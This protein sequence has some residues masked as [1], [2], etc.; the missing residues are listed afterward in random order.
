MSDNLKKYSFNDLLKLG[1]IRIPKIQRDYAQGRQNQ[2]VDEIRKV[3]VHTLLLVVKGKRPATELDF[4]YGSINNNAFEPL[5]GQQRLTTLFLLHW[6]MGVSL[7]MPEDKKHSIFTYETRNT[8]NEFCDELVQHEA[9]NIVQETIKN[10][11]LN[12]LVKD[13]KEKKPELPS[14]IIK[15]RDWFKWEWK[16]DPTILSML[17]MIDAIF[18]EMG[19]DWN[20]DL[21]VYRN[22]LEHITFNLLNLG[23]FGLSN[24]LFIKMNARGKQLSDFD[25]L[26]STLEEE[27]QIQ[28]KEM[29]EQGNKLASEE[30]EEMWRSLMDG[31]W[32][33]LFW[34]KYARQMIDNTETI[35]PEERKKDR[36]QAAKLSELQFKKLLLR[37]IALQLFENNPSSEKLAEAS[38]NLE[39]STIDNLLFV[40]TDSLTDLRSDETHT[41]V[42]STSLTIN[43]KRLIEDINLLIYKDS[44][45]I[46]YD[47]SYLLPE[48]S[49]IDKDKSSLFDTFLE[50]KVPNDVELIFYA[51]LLF[52]RSFP[53]KKYK[54]SEEEPIAWYFDK[55]AHN[56]WLKNYEDWVRSTRNILLN[57]N[58]N[59]RIDKI[60][61]SKEATQSLKQMSADLTAFVEE[62]GLDIE[63]DSTIIKQFFKSSN[64]N[65]QRLD[66]QSL[67]EERRKALLVLDDNKE[68]ESF[69]DDAE[70]HPY[71]WGQIRCLLNW[72]NGNLDSFKEYSKRLRQLLDCIK[73]NGLLY[74][75][76]ILSFAPNCW[77]ENNRLFLYN[78]D[79]DNSFKR[80]LREHTKE[81]QAYGVA[82]KSLIDIW[83]QSYSSLS[84]SEFLD[85]LI[86]TKKDN[87]APWI[88]CIIKCPSVL[89]ETWNKR[90]YFQNGHVIIAQRKTRDSHCFDP[91][92]IYL[93]N[94]CREKKILENKY[95]LYDSK[96]KPEHAF[97]LEKDNHLLLVEWYGTEGCYSI[98]IDNT[99]ESVYSP[100]EIIGFMEKIINNS[101]EEVSEIIKALV[102]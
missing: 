35:A 32:I 31:T 57:D 6:M 18:T 61:F 47:I 89:E 2:K 66:N 67:A 28:Q 59:Q 58:N 43:F 91:I 81:G 88:Q 5:D 55:N 93:R 27:L 24:E 70:K 4:V 12:K 76:A 23:A 72:S 42:P 7:S 69:I 65:Y 62:K 64:K 3:F 9:F 92:L 82:I 25:K 97:Q 54:K 49:H 98:K 52:L 22:N 60:Q 19:T 11:E 16:Y 14:I 74:Y 50:A 86:K 102:K 53:E 21:S 45:D 48:I 56:A 10:I 44:N 17:V 84:V 38:Y 63:N 79:R 40:Y 41:V 94:L 34:H 51:M 90:I 30:D 83:I 33:D 8:S 46:F 77:E 15:G 87:S 99:S 37:L 1:K 26:K 13:D 101:D 71:L 68:W 80:Y 39:E 20:M 100:D 73:E 96:D 78:K 95:H 75:S 29:D 36:L 85:A